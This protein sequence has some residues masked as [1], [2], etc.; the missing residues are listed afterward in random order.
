MSLFV[1]NYLL[2]HVSPE[3]QGPQDDRRI[4]AVPP[5]AGADPLHN[6]IVSQ[7]RDE[8]DPSEHFVPQNQEERR[9]TAARHRSG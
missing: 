6:N 1:F 5:G 9:K 3:W 7:G 4:D 2:G 8:G